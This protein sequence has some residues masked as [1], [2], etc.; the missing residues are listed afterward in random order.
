MHSATVITF[1]AVETLIG[2]SRGGVGPGGSG[3][4]LLS[5]LKKRK[6]KN[7]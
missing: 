6:K 7:K 3:P 4:P 5:K 1:F 2:G